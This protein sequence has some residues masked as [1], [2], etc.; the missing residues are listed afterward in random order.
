MNKSLELNFWPILCGSIVYLCLQTQKVCLTKHN[1]TF[2]MGQKIKLQIF[3]RMH[4]WKK[5]ENRSIFGKAM[6]KTLWLTFLGHPVCPCLPLFPLGSSVRTRPA[7]NCFFGVT[8]YLNAASFP[9]D[10]CGRS[11]ASRIGHIVALTYHP[12]F[13]V[14]RD[15]S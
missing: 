15:P 1:L 3:H 5:F 12:E 2:R 13:T 10:I 14:I 9:C 4:Q 11:C 8:L 6:D 7:S